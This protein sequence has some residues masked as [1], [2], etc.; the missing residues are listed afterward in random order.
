MKMLCWLFGSVAAAIALMGFQSA[1]AQT[2]APTPAGA[3]FCV[4]VPR[5]PVTH[6]QMI[7]AY[8]AEQMGAM[9]PLQAQQI[10]QIYYDQMLPPP[11]Y[12]SYQDSGSCKIAAGVV[13]GTCVA[14]PNR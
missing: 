7:G 8:T 12:C 1:S 9:S 10:R 2:Q 6:E 13:G 14:N 11:V 4:M 5:V 3:P